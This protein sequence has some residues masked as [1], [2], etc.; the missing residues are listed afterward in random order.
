MQSV[1]SVLLA[2]ACRSMRRFV[3]DFKKKNLPL[4]CLINNAGVE[5]PPDRRTPEGLDVSYPLS[6]LL[7]SSLL[8]HA[9]TKHACMHAWQVH[10]STLEHK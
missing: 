5:N 10:S 2:H 1:V 4:H 8:L 7:A 6:P 9:P 3:D